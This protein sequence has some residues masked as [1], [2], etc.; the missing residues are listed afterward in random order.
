MLNKADL[1]ID[2]NGVSLEAALEDEAFRPLLAPWGP[3]ALVI[4]AAKGWGLEEL[5]R[6]LEAALA[7][8]ASVD[9]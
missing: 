9:V 6:R 3:Q 5:R 1:L 7:E 4:S 8:A 2:G